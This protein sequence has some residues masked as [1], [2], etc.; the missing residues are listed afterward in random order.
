MILRLAT[1]AIAAAMLAGTA[2]A[3]VLHDNGPIVDQAGLSIL[4]PPDITL[5]FSANTAARLA[6]NF[7]VSGPSWNV[8]SISFY[9]YQT[10][11]SGFTFTSASWSI[12]SGND[13]NTGAT[14]ASGTSSVTNGGLV[15]YRVTNT[16]LAN[17]QR[18]IFEI[19]ADMPDFTLGAG[20]Y[21]VTWQLFGT[22]ASGPFVPPVLGSLGSG[23]ALQATTGA[24]FAITDGGT[25]QTADVPF[26]INGNAVPEPASWALMILGFGAVGGSLRARRRSAVAA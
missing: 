3:A 15:G 17:T 2:Q 11:S 9:G 10:N 4:T 16:T 25:G 1:T 19:I 24:Y 8:E 6:D 14:V 13:V 5:G 23:N 21:F 22:G 26:T 12:V 18:P 20:N 7:T